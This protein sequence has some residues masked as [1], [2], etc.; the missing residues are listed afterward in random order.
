MSSS[1][2]PC[3]H[4]A[5]RVQRASR[6]HVGRLVAAFI[7]IALA[8]VSHAAPYVPQ[9]DDTV[10]DRVPAGA[11]LRQFQPLRG[12]VAANP[13]DMNA[14]LRLSKAYLD[15]G[16]R[17]GDPRFISY[18]QA[19]L[20][21]WIQRS[22][23][24]AAALVLGAIVLQSS[25]RF[26]ASLAMLERA[27]HSDPANAQ[28]LL[29]KAT[30]LQ[31][32]GD[33]SAARKTCAQLTAAA[34][35]VIAIACLTGTNSMNG[36][37]PESYQLLEQVFTDDARLPAEVRSWMRGQLG[38]MSARLGADTLAEQH[39]KAAL[40]ADPDDLYIKGEYA[41]LLLRQHR[42][43]ETIVLLQNN[44]AQD[45]LLLRL[46]IV[47]TATNTGHRWADM[48]DAR[49]EAARRDGDNTHLREQARFALEVRGD[50]GEALTLAR[51]NWQIQR[52]PAD[53]RIYMRA[54]KAARNAA[55]SNEI[56]VW[57]STTGYQ[58]QTLGVLSASPIARVLP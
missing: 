1:I 16:R 33:F 42:A 27:L 32:R 14:V 41:D 9:N 18:A 51:Q 19:T 15:I 13:G 28:A 23:A 39:F 24:P 34:G 20:A 54:A 25:H 17:N 50:A 11:Q 7:A 21:P 2:Q 38:E 3:R 52:E 29:T 43:Q 48:Y 58:D 22:D 47:E 36:K 56:S 26:D 57:I 31:V 40:R 30:V 45:A 37:L 53:V 4:N 44:E 55:A 10:L 8:A 35:Q 6:P 49:Y 5:L 46:A 12:G